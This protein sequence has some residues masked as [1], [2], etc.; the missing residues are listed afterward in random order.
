V[1]PRSAVSAGSDESTTTV[2]VPST[3]KYTCSSYSYCGANGLAHDALEPRMIT[4]QA[5][6]LSNRAIIARMIYCAPP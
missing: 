6:R 5:A 4:S 3:D 1:I 2:A